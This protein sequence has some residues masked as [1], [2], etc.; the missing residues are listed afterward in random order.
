MSFLEHLEELR[1]HL[2][3]S[4]LAIVIVGTAAFIAKD[5]IFDTLIFG[6]KKSDFFTY[7]LFCTIKNDGQGTSFCLQELPFR[8][9]VAV[10]GQFSA[11]MDFNHRRFYFSFSLYLIEFWKFIS[12][13]F[14]ARATKCTVSS[15]WLLSV[16]L[17]VLFGYYIVTPLSINFLGSYTV[18]TGLNDFDLASYIS[19]LRHPYF[20]LVSFLNYQF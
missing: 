15:L 3:R 2:I 9:K 6:P 4:S 1:W 18:V 14:G 10:S 13:G 11:S 5:F 12:P 17:G 8:I 7:E 20:R 19:L 16:F